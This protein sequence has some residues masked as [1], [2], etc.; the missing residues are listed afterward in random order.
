[1][2]AESY[3]R[4]GRAI[5]ARVE[6]EPHVL[7]LVATGSMARRTREPDE[8]SDHDFW[9]ITE[10]GAEERY[11]ATREWLPD[12][13][14]IVLAFRETAH[15]I[16]VVYDDGH[17]VEYA[18][19]APDE[20]SAT[21]AN[22]YRVL[23]DRERIGERMRA[24]RDATIDGVPAHDFTAGQFLTQLLVAAARERR[25]ERLS[26]RSLIVSAVEHLTRLLAGHTP[27]ERPDA[28][29]DIDPRRRFELAFPR[30]AA[31][32]DAA[33]AGDPERAAL[34]LL[35]LAE[36]ELEPRSA[37]WPTAAAAVVRRYL[38]S[39]RAGS[40]QPGG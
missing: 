21:R 25:G 22:E 24:V 5:L 16:K 35:V 29:D 18:V 12:A 40:R 39:D 6:A 9:L 4:F 27:A 13:D 36:R 26:A 30:L 32:I 28:V 23:L 3:R 37:G 10:A 15:G 8:W 33:L 17:L 31:E 19:F 20:L 7:G 14:R 38:E 2:D 34:F 11:R 1:M